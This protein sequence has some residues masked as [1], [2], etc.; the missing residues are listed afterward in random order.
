MLRRQATERPFTGTYTDTEEPGVYRCA[1]C[2]AELFRSDAKFHS[3]S[4]WPSF[5]EPAGARLRS[6]PAIDTSHGMVRTEVVCAACG[7]HLGHLFDDG[8]GP[9]GMRLLHQ[10]V[11]PRSRSR[12]PMG[13][14]PADTRLGAI[15]LRAGDIGLLRDFYETSDR[16]RG[17]RSPRTTPSPPSARRDEPLVELVSDPDAPP[18]PPRTTGLFHLALLVPTRADLARA[19]RRVADSGWHLSGASDHLV[20]E[21]LYLSDPEGNG[22]ELYRDRPREEWPHAGGEIEMAT[23]PLDLEGLLVRARGRDADAPAMP[24]GRCSAT[25]ICRSPTWRRRRRFWV[26]GLGFDVIVRGYPGALFVSAGGYH[27]HVGLNTW[28]GVGAPPPPEGARGLDRFEI[29][30]PDE[31][32]MS[33]ARERLATASEVRRFGGERRRRRSLRQRGPG[34]SRA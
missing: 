30:L 14:L 34:P 10:L 1:G 21:A 13:E 26:D 3:G 19:L 32:S 15:R 23:L 20:S 16:A 33:A 24:A 2:G 7:G 6:R 25:S 28:A 22:I 4:G 11:R 12:A 18:R 29:V 9:T 8:P 31:A 5:V 27:H 17:A